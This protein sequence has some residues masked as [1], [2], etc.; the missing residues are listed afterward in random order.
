[1]HPRAQSLDRRNYRSQAY[2]DFNNPSVYV[3]EYAITKMEEDPKLL[4]LRSYSMPRHLQ[5]IENKYSFNGMAPEGAT[6]GSDYEFDEL[7]IHRKN[8]RPR[9]KSSNIFIYRSLSKN[10][11]LDMVFIPS[12]DCIISLKITSKTRLS[13][14]VT[15]ALDIFK[16]FLNSI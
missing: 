7:P 1:M 3:N 4:K 11:S 14:S 6:A 13:Q 15:V 2:A 8:K 9:E 10:L 12:V 5:P 16:T